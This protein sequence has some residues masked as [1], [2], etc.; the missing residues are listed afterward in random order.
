MET[1]DYLKQ[2]A[3]ELHTSVMATVDK[4][5]QAMLRQS[6][7]DDRTLQIQSFCDRRTS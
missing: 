3:E 5:V 6:N 4:P 1:K 2:I 7:Y